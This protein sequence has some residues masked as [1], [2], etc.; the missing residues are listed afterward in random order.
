M[1]CT[2][3]LRPQPGSEVTAGVRGCSQDGGPPPTSSSASPH[4]ASSPHLLVQTNNFHLFFLPEGRKYLLFQG[5]YLCLFEVDSKAHWLHDGKQTRGV[6]AAPLGGPLGPSRESGLRVSPDGDHPLRPAPSAV[7]GASSMPLLLRAQRQPGTLARPQPGTGT[8]TGTTQGQGGRA[9]ARRGG[10]PP[11]RTGGGAAA[12]RLAGPTSSVP[13]P[14][15]AR[16]PAAGAPPADLAA[17]DPACARE[18]EGTGRSSRRFLNASESASWVLVSRSGCGDPWLGNVPP[19][20]PRAA[21]TGRPMRI[22]RSLV[23]WL[24]TWLTLSSKL[25]TEFNHQ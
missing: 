9:H 12:P 11:L 14:D 13:S 23:R 22:P 2:M 21:P 24:K 8:G 10:P 6:R 18:T 3:R 5:K 16:R 17:A 25:I 20:L 1:V 19:G 7:K 4:T 15:R